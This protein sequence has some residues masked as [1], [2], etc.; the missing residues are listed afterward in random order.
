MS[1]ATTP[2]HH[3]EDAP[4]MPVIPIAYIRYSLKEVK[5]RVKNLELMCSFMEDQCD[6]EN[7]FGLVLQKVSAILSP[8]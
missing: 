8:R 3:L 1:A 5:D 6:I 2:D 4:T 7:R